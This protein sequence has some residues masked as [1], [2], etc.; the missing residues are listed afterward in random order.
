MNIPKTLQ[1]PAPNDAAWQA[2]SVFDWLKKHGPLPDTYSI[3]KKALY[4]TVFN[5]AYFSLEQLQLDLR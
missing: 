3:F 4:N 2:E 5:L 1:N